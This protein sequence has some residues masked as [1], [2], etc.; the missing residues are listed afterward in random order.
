MAQINGCRSL[1]VGL[2]VLAFCSVCILGKSFG[3][4]SE[5]TF[6]R[7]SNFLGDVYQSWRDGFNKRFGEGT[8]GLGLRPSRWVDWTQIIGPYGKRNFNGGYRQ[9]GMQ[10]SFGRA[11]WNFEDDDFRKRSE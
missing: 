11:M 10:P 8:D 1:T 6:N 5:D 3:G 7:P 2:V 4:G 9:F